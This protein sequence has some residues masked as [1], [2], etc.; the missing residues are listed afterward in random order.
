MGHVKKRMVISVEMCY[1]MCFTCMVL[2]Q[3]N[4]KK[5]KKYGM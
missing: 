5:K 4:E 2:C 3:M 1:L